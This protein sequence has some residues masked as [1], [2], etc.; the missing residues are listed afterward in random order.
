MLTP[1]V[2]QVRDN[3]QMVRSREVCTDELAA[4]V[5]RSG[6]LIAIAEFPNGNA[7]RQP[8]SWMGP[9][10]RQLPSGIIRIIGDHYREITR[11]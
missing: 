10:S 3:R 11:V 6:G 7:R 9:D 8:N 2:C 4:G 1:D 5:G